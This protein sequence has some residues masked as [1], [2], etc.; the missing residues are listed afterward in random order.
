MSPLRI[1]FIAVSVVFITKMGFAA[2]VSGS[3]KK[4]NDF[5]RKGQYDQALMH[6]N[7][8]YVDAPDSDIVNFDIGAASYQKGDYEKAIEAFNK[9]LVS[10]NPGIEEKAAY[11]IGNSK[12]RLGR[13]LKEKK[14]L[15]SAAN[16]YRQAL[17]YYKQAIELN[18]KNINA[19][20]NHEF[21]ERELKALLDKLKQQEEKPEGSGQKEKEEQKEQEEYAQPDASKEEQKEEGE[22]EEQTAQGEEQKEEEAEGQK[23]KEGEQKEMSEEEARMILERYNQEGQLLDN[24]S[25]DSKARHYLPVLKD[26]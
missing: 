21:V 12:Y 20:Y 13:L 26:W 18:P 9:A 25:L 11:N 1:I 15:G 4:G 5:Y 10:D 19:K 17:D 6:Y 22:S 8:A 7:E 3:V 14:D 16:L 2:S 23:L 24:M